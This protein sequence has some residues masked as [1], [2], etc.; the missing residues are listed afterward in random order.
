VN[1]APNDG[2][3]SARSAELGR[4]AEELDVAAAL[5][6]HTCSASIPV[7][8]TAVPSNTQPPTTNVRSTVLLEAGVSIARSTLETHP[9]G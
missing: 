4:R 3:T 9:H 7:P 2:A 5:T 8:L 1:C 6:A